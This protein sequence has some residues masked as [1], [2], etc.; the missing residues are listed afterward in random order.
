MWAHADI[1]DAHAL[2]ASIAPNCKIRLA[3]TME[4]GMPVTSYQC[5]AVLWYQRRYWSGWRIVQQRMVAGDAALEKGKWKTCC[6]EQGKYNNQSGRCYCLV[7]R[8]MVAVKALE[9]K[10]W[11]FSEI[12][13]EI[14]DKRRYTLYVKVRA[15]REIWSGLT[16]IKWWLEATSNF[17][18]TNSNNT[19]L[20]IQGLSLRQYDW[21]SFQG[22]CIICKKSNCHK[23]LCSKDSTHH[24]E[25]QEGFR[26]FYLLGIHKENTE[27]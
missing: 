16:E 2:V 13:F 5:S 23:L 3:F 26:P 19:S 12:V 17:K 1:T 21:S 4:G 22:C 9:V 14:F 24:K 20:G 18:I 25:T 10:Y 11:H 6:S 7:K 15:L 8:K 27:I